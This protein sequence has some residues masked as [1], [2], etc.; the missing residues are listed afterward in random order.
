MYVCA[1]ID[2]HAHVNTHTCTQR[3]VASGLSNELSPYPSPKLGPMK[4]DTP[5]AAT[6]SPTANGDNDAGGL[7]DQEV[8]FRLEVGGWIWLV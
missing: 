8:C 7:A 4:V 3:N 2:L 5:P 1:H 6:G